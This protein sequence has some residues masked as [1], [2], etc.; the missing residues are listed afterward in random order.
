MTS[1]YSGD[2]SS[3]ERSFNASTRSYGRGSLRPAK[4]VTSFDSI[5]PQVDTTISDT[6]TLEPRDKFTVS[7]S[8]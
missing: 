4:S 1:N 7:Y 3:L 8:S 6:V 5:T 2:D